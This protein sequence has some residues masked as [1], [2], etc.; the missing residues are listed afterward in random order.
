MRPHVENRIDETS[1]FSFCNLAFPD[2]L[3]AQ[4]E[5][6]LPANGF[7]RARVGG[8]ELYVE[9]GMAM[10]VFPDQ[11]HGYSESTPNDGALLIFPPS[12]V[13]EPQLDFASLCPNCSAVRLTRPDECYA[14]RRLIEEVSRQPLDLPVCLALLRLLM[15][16]LIPRLELRSVKG[17]PVSD[18]LYRALKYISRHAT[19]PITIRSTAHALGVNVYYLSH[20]MNEKLQ[21]GFHEYLVTLRLDQTSQ[22]L[23]TTALSVSEVADQCGFGSL[24]TFDRQ[25]LRVYGMTPRAYRNA[26]KG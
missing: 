13:T 12:L 23:R 7:V 11:V 19:Q 24:R 20:I 17:L 8:E 26:H 14:V 4:M 6:V 10:V 21:M 5:L 25:F 2:H 1:L 9:P 18:L 16:N 3:H 22:L 15:V